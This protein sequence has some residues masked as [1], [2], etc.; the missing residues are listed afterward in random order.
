MRSLVPKR[1]GGFGSFWH[2]AAKQA[3]HNNVQRKGNH[4]EQLLLMLA[5]EPD[6]NVRACSATH[7]SSKAVEQACQ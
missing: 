3:T 5:Q 6:A 4:T 2:G 1:P 7:F